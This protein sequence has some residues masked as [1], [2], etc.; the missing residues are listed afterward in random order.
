MRRSLERAAAK[1]VSATVCT[2]SR[3]SRVRCR[4]TA[5]VRA[6]ALTFLPH[7]N[8]SKE[9]VM[10]TGR[11]I[12]IAALR[13]RKLTLSREAEGLLAAA[14]R[15]N[16][17]LT[18]AEAAQ[19]ERSVARLKETEA[20]LIEAEAQLE[21]ERRM[22]GMPDENALFARR[23]GTGSANAGY[24]AGG[25]LEGKGGPGKKKYRD[26]FP[27]AAHHLDT[28]GFSSFD[29][30]L[31][32]WHNTPQ[33]FDPRLKA[34]QQ[35]GIPSS[36]GFAVPEEFA[37]ML[38]DKA[39][40][41]EVVRPRAQVWPLASDTRK[42][43]ALDNFDHSSNLYGGFTAQWVP[44]TGTITPQDLKTRLIQ[45]TA[46][47]LALLG[48]SSNELLDD[49]VNGFEA[50][51]GASMIAAVSYFYDYYF[52]RGD[53][54]GQPLGVLNDPALIVIAKESGQAANTVD[55]RNVVK[56]FARLHPACLSNAVWI[57]NSTTIPQL[58][59]M[60][61]RVFNLAASDVVGGSAVP[62]VTQNADGS[63]SLLTR[64]II[65]TEKL[66]ALSSQGDLLLADL[67]QYAIGM[68]KGAAIEK[69]M[70]AGFTTDQ[71]YF[72]VI[73]RLDGQGTWKSA[74]TPKNG[75]SLSWC[76]TLAA[77]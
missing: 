15:E 74:V 22:Q 43:P 52:L 14:M 77:R 39:L 45:L 7:L 37:A 3:T 53:G 18:S 62:A 59:Q 60:Q 24:S 67:S 73:T 33:Q 50:V 4:K 19:H 26:L 49:A 58:L 41:A 12:P 55:Y 2:F 25:S 70:H 63:M 1:I 40:E 44:E 23:A 72:R 9:I 21:A 34:S 54:A 5:D 8:Q 66:P 35:E 71:T 47:K 20:E 65:F 28:G 31:Q 51:Y 36:G 11:I 29:E 56:M 48:A 6:Q 42:V 38:I 76:V 46:K 13:H 64:P 10:T 57:A 27:N 75:D 30:F 16:R 68:R 61:N 32:A 17:D 69:S